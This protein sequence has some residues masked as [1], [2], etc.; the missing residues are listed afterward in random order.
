[1]RYVQKSFCSCN[2][3]IFL[4][5][6]LLFSMLQLGNHYLPQEG[7]TYFIGGFVY[8]LVFFIVVLIL[9]LN[10]IFG[11][12]I[13]QFGALRDLQNRNAY[14]REHT[15]FICGIDRTTYDQG[16]LKR[17]FAAPR[18]GF[19]AHVQN[20]HNMWDYLFYLAHLR[21][22][23]KTEYSGAETFLD[24]CIKD[25][26]MEWVPNVAMGLGE[27]KHAFVVPQDGK[28]S[29]Q[30]R[31]G[32]ALQEIRSQMDE[33]LR[34]QQQGMQEIA[35]A[36]KHLGVRVSQNVHETTAIGQSLRDVQSILNEE[37]RDDVA[38]STRQ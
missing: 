23:P 22:K 26:N 17:N 36:V 6:F 32:A 14:A 37:Y 15:C 4:T 29:T 16:A 25:D 20:E 31:V 38:E 5:L 21:H 35:G 19:T 27:A 33:G 13:D 3:T 30:F 7:T 34:A 28:S 9:L 11:I 8:G 1:M 12:I 18:G 10:I 24:R 2:V